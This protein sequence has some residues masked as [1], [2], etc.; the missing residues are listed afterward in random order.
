MKQIVTKKVSAVV[1]GDSDSSKFIYRRLKETQKDA[2]LLSARDEVRFVSKQIVSINGVKTQ[3]SKVLLDTHKRSE[4]AASIS[5]GAVVAIGSDDKVLSKVFTAMGAAQSICLLT[6]DSKLLQN[7][8]LAVQDVVLRYLKKSK[9]KVLFDTNVLSTRVSE[10][11]TYIV[12]E[13]SGVP[14]RIVADTLVQTLENPGTQDEMGLHNAV[15]EDTIQELHS[16]HASCSITKNIGVLKSDERLTLS[17]VDLIVD[18]MKSRRSRFSIRKPP[19]QVMAVSGLCAFSIGLIE[20]S[21]TGA[22]TGYRKSVVKLPELS[23]ASPTYF[24][25]IIASTSGRLIGVSGVI[26]DEYF[27]LK[28][29]SYFVENK[30]RVSTAK[31]MIPLSSSHAVSLYE[32]L[33]SL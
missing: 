18:F 33:D 10:N 32:A 13:H 16:G 24:I 1:F 22:H 15:P 4:S 11:K 12:A 6:H 28:L 3:A 27:D 19:M 8:D 17:D 26:P 7:Y 23:P 14:R 31:K 30:T 9:V 29:L 25:K 2:L 20:Q 21:I 5:T